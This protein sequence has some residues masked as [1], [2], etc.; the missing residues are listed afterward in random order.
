MRSPDP[1][2]G[3]LQ[4]DRHRTPAGGRLG[5]ARADTCRPQAGAAGAGLVSFSNKSDAITLDPVAAR[6]RRMSGSVLLG[7]RLLDEGVRE[8]G[9]RGRWL[10]VTTTYRPGVEWEP[11]HV[12][13][14]MACLRKWFARRGHRLCCQWVAEMQERGA[15]HYHAV[16]WLPRGLTLPKS[17]K[18]GWW[19]HGSTKTEVARSPVG[20]MAKYASKGQ[21]GP[22]FPR[23][24]RIHGS[25]GL[26]RLAMRCK[27]WAMAPSRVRSAFPLD[28]GLPPDL[29]R[30]RGGGWMDRGTG[31]HLPSEWSFA[32]F[33]GGKVVLVPRVRP[34][35]EH[36]PERLSNSGIHFACETFRA[37]A[38]AAAMA[39]ASFA[40]TDGS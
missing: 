11:G 25:A 4:A 31:E 27:R 2:P 5:A 12:S 22:L 15:V 13:A 32:G 34:P 10:M 35:G 40:S 36:M 14:F 9:K 1:V 33:V 24:C 38:E 26:D 29:C 19:P 17:D 21:Q 20:Y 39:W 3:N 6:L 7:A 30:P 23:G 18:R 8:G 37:S 28:N 16:L